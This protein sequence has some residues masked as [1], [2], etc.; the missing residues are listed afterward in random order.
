MSLKPD[1]EFVKNCLLKHFGGASTAWEG[2]DP[3][4]IYMMVDGETI[5]VEITRLSPVSFDENGIVQNRNTEDNFGINLCNEL[6][7]KMG[8]E[9]PPEINILLTLYVPVENARNYKKQLYQLLND[10]LRKGIEIGNEYEFNIA[11]E[12]VEINIIPIRKYSQK[13]VVGIIFNK[14]SSTH[15]QSNAEI[16]LSERLLDKVKKCKNI[17]YQGSKWL[18]L[19]NDYWL[20][21]HEMYAAALNNITIEHNFDRI[22]VINHAG[23]VYQVH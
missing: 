18:A 7:S 14:N 19:F 15:I 21:D 6:N 4:D 17:K 1:E 2:E 3:P 16:I 9:I 22:L 23:Q 20:A 11:G 10:T 5:A 8:K 12:K 13:K